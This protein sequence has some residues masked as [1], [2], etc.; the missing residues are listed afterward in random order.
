MHKY[1]KNFLVICV[2]FL[3]ILCVA[4]TPS[5]AANRKGSHRVGGTNG[6]GKGGHY[7]GGKLVQRNSGSFTLIN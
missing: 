4:V 3:F 7:E 1:L 2:A 6:H 5:D